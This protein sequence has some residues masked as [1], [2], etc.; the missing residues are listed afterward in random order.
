MKNTDDE[1]LVD[2]SRKGDRTALDELSERYM[3]YA[4]KKAFAFL[5][6]GMEYDDIVQTAML[7]FLSALYSYNGENGVK[8][9]TFVSRCMDNAVLNSIEH[10]NARKR[11]PGQAVLSYEEAD[12][13]YL[14]G[15]GPEEEFFSK[16]RL[17]AVFRA[18]D[19]VLNEYEKKVI[20]LYIQGYT[21]REIADIS[22]TD[23]KKVDKAMQSLRK[24]LRDA[25]Q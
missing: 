4:E 18:I 25:V 6:R 12:L 7:G 17:K 20:L 16:E 21:Y 10:I 5:N 23:Y 8:F 9:V 24:K 2:L 1:I 13:S 22:E 3:K 14:I 11:N 15:E 19:T